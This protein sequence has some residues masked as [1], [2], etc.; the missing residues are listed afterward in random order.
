MRTT[1]RLPWLGV[2][3]LIITA[4]GL[5]ACGGGASSGAAQPT[6]APAAGDTGS[7]AATAAP[8]AGAAQPTAAPA[9]GDTASTAAGNSEIIISLNADPPK[10]DPAQSSAFVDRQVLNNICD[11]LAD[12]DAQG[13]IVPM[14]ATEWKISDDKLAYTF[15]L[16]EGVKFHDGTDFNAD[17]V[18]ANLAR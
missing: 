17:A 3:L 2:V 10:L 16:R 6:A 15:T 11:K 12:I 5:S 1:N 4:L 18:K 7:T 8:A 14:L 13:K 9:A